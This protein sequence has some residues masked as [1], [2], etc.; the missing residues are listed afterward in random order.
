MEAPCQGP[1]PGPASCSVR[2]PR[3]VGVWW[4]RYSL[5]S[6]RAVVRVQSPMTPLWD[7]GGA[8]PWSNGSRVRGGGASG[9]LQA[10]LPRGSGR[11]PRGGAGQTPGAGAGG[12][13]SAT[14]RSRQARHAHHQR[15]RR[16]PAP[17]DVYVARRRHRLARH[18]TAAAPPQGSSVARFRRA[19]SPLGAPPARNRSRLWLAGESGWSAGLSARQSPSTLTP[20]RNGYGR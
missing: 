20:R 11:Q 10:V 14:R 6:G 1:F 4:V 18:R 16:P 19:P 9:R 8:T 13:R 15:T 5:T 12:G 7:Q 2:A 3:P 17:T